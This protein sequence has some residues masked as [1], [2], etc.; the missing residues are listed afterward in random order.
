M[1]TYDFTQLGGFPG[2]QSV[3]GRMQTAYMEA[4]LGIANAR[5]LSSPFVV[6]GCGQ[7]ISMG[8][9]VIAAGWI[10]YNGV[11]IR[12]P[13]S[14]ATATYPN[15]ILVQI[16]ETDSSLVFNDGSTPS[17]V[18]EQTAALVA[19]ASVTDATHFPLS[20]LVYAKELAWSHIAVSAGAVVGDI[21]YKKHVANNSLLIRGTLTITN[22]SASSTPTYVNIGTLGSGYYPVSEKVPFSAKNRYHTGIVLDAA[23][24]AYITALNGEV[25]TA[26][27]INLGVIKCAGTSYA[28]EFY[29][30]IPL[31]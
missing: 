12:V 31:D 28:V 2:D 29:E 22:S 23:A 13:G 6:S 10:V 15:V 18:K 24:S 5:G 4:L 8:A 17:V 16:T 30:V 11:L 20:S 7:S 9:T 21:Y 27:N 1:K 19:G 14:S 3:L 25:D 26:G